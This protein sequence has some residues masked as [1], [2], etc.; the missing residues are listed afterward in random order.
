MVSYQRF[1]GLIE[2]EYCYDI[3]KNLAFRVSIYLYDASTIFEMMTKVTVYSTQNCPYCR[4]AK[5][6]LEKHGV[7]YESID[8]GEDTEAAKKMIDLS[9]QRG[10]PV[11]VVDD[12]VIVGFDSAEPQ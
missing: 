6:F 8:V 2:K 10:V 9:G 1:M 4:M 3:G 12:E 7:P 5:A 11:I